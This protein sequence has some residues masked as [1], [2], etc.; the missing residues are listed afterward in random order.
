MFRDDSLAISK[1]ISCGQTEKIQTDFQKLFQQSNL[2][3]TIRCNHIIVSFFDVALH[4]AD[5]TYHP[6][7]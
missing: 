7:H 6:N 4:L 3:L 5:F 2:K 1:N